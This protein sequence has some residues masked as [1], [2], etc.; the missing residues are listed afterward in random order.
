MAGKVRLDDNEQ[1]HGGR[2]FKEKLSVREEFY[3]LSNKGRNV[4]NKDIWI[5]GWTWTSSSGEVSINLQ[6]QSN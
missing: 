3:L 6:K 2:Y 4:K 5:Y 1:V